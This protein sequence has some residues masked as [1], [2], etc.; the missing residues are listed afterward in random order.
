MLGSEGGESLLLFDM[1]LVCRLVLDREFGC[2]ALV[3]CYVLHISLDQ[4]EDDQL[5]RVPGSIA[6]IEYVNPLLF[7]MT[8]DGVVCILHTYVHVHASV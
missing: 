8:T 3:G 7:A 6:C 1:S 4:Y 5:P 2:I